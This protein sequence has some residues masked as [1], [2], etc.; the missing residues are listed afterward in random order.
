MAG[1]AVV[2]WD[3]VPA[4]GSSRAVIAQ[5]F[6]SAGASV[7]SPFQVNTYTLYTQDVP[8]VACTDAGDF[9]V[10]WRS[11]RQD[12]GNAGSVFGQRFGSDGARL[13][14]EFQ[15]NTYTVG[16]QRRP[17]VAAAAGGVFVVVWH[18]YPGQD[19]YGRGI[20]GQRFDSAG[21]PSGTEFLVNTFTLDNQTLRRRRRRI[22]RRL[23]RRLAELPERNP[24]RLRPALRQLRDA[25]G[26][27]VQGQH[28]SSMRSFPT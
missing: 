28:S 4:D 12:D 3:E 7:G 11:D 27:G 2:V 16:S 20:F 5:R 8:S 19:G 1:N 14:S 6:D 18:S 21:A 13:G 9:V 15:V 26:N 23:R 10:V 24:R 22:E 25:G 17:D